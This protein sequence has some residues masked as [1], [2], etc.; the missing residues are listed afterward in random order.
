MHSSSG[1]QDGA[2]TSS[3]KGWT[4]LRKRAIAGAQR[5]S[6]EDLAGFRTFGLLRD[7]PR[8]LPWRMRQRTKSALG[9]ARSGLRFDDAHFV[10]AKGYGLWLLKAGDIGCLVEAGHATL[11]CDTFSDADRRGF[12]LG[13]YRT[14]HRRS[15]APHDFLALG[16]A[17]D[18]AKI[19]T[20]RAGRIRRAVK[21][22]NGAYAMKSSAP[23]TLIDLRR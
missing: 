3:D 23:I 1:G 22:S 4:L 5:A 14:P 16:I 17:P 19:V 21:V 7:R 15:E 18:W 9:V 2:A 8:S 11:S 6:G 10:R 20:L 12:F 13:V